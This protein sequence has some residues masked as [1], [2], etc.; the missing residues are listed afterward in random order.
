MG[1]ISVY[2]QNMVRDVTYSTAQVAQKIGVHKLTLLRWLYAGRIPEP[3]HAQAGNLDLRIWSAED[4][5]RARKF[6]SAN[7]RV[8]RV[9][10][11]GRPKK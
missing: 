9:K 1:E 11:R 3:R 7:Y 6:K 5:A 10:G 4:L 8:A 2:P